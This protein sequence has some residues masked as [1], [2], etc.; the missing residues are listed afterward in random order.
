MDTVE[1][2]RLDQRL[3]RAELAKMMIVYI[4]KIKKIT[5]LKTDEPK[6]DDVDASL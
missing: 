3:T 5:P 1:K 4:Q 2:A 6:Y